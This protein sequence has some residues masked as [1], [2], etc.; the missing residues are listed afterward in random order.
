MPAYVT[1]ARSH[2]DAPV[3]NQTRQ[4]FYHFQPHAKLIDHHFVLRIVR[5]QSP[6]WGFTLNGLC[7]DA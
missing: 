4:P 1:A 2:E 5:V 6:H 3:T 7:H